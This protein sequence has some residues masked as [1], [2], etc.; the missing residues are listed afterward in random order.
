MPVSHRPERTRH[1]PTHRVN[2][3][4]FLHRPKPASEGPYDQPLS[5]HADCVALLGRKYPGAMPDKGLASS[6]TLWIQA[7]NGIEW[8]RLANDLP[9]FC[10]SHQPRARAAHRPLWRTITPIQTCT[11]KQYPKSHNRDPPFPH[12]RHMAR[13]AWGP[14]SYENRLAVDVSSKNV[15]EYGRSRKRQINCECTVPQ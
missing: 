2:I 4:L 13:G 10:P 7:T 11:N 9:H 15:H 8:H 12:R 1:R 3:A 5:A 14:A 6:F